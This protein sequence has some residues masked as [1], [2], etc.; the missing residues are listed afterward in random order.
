VPRLLQQAGFRQWLLTDDPW[1]AQAATS[2]ALDE[3]LLVETTANG[4]V[5]EIEETAFAQFFSLA[6]EQLSDWRDEI[7]DHPEGSLFWLHTRGFL[8]PWDAP[9]RMRAERLNEEDPPPA[10]FVWPPKELRD[11]DDPDVLLAHRVAYSAQVAVLDACLG[12]FLQA[13]EPLLQDKETLLLLLG[14][15]GFA[16]GEHGSIGADCQDLFSEQLH[17]PWLLHKWGTSAPLARLTGLAQPADVGA[18]LLDWFGVE[19]N[20]PLADGHSVLPVLNC[21]Q[22]EPRQTSVAYN[23]DDGQLVLRTPA[24]MLRAYPRTALDVSSGRKSLDNQA[25]VGRAVKSCQSGG[26]NPSED[27]TV[28]LY[29]KPDDRWECNDVAILC[30]QIVDLLQE[31]ID[32]FEQQCLQNEPLTSEKLDEELIAPTR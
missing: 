24:W 10:D 15:R 6:V 12:A 13:V 25:V 14:S 28:E 32:R 17:V 18:T 26:D 31:E 21:P 19:P 4:S 1:L 9:R 29:V 30:P 3:S 20:L 11:V 27:P 7:D 2:M 8:G 23:A 22:N 5:D 16:L